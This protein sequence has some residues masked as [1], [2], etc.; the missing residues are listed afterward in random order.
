ME[1]IAAAQ[2]DSDFIHAGTGAFR[3]LNV[4]MFAAA[5]S[6]FA[7]IYCVQPLMPL[8]ATSFSVTP[9]VSSL[10]LSMN[11]AALGIAIV[12]AGIVSEV[13]G[14]RPV[15]TVSLIAS[16]LLTLGTAVAPDWHTLLLTRA[17]AGLALSGV[18]AVAVAY[19]TEEVDPRAGGLAMGLYVAGTAFGGMT[20]RLL[21]G[22]LADFLSWRWAIAGIG[23]L[24]L[25]ASILFR[26]LLPPSRHFT[27]REPRL[28]L[29]GE[30]LRSHLTERG[31]LSLFL[32]GFLLMGSFVS[33][34]NYIGFR[35]LAPPYR[36]SHAAVGLIFVIYLIGMIASAWSGPLAAR[37]GSH[38]VLWTMVVVMLAGLV[39]T[40]ASPL[41]IVI[42]GVA[43]MTFGFFGGH[44][45]LSAWIGRR[46][47]RAKALASSLYL[48]FFYAGSSIAGTLTGRFWS[49]AGWNGVSAAVGVLL[50]MALFVALG[51]RRV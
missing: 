4:A 7:L 17:L 33:V 29:L 43:V 41:P 42:L 28:S 44:T 2:A 39:I 46:A 24:S 51:L 26:A 9:A 31:M 23:A 19:V 6:T 25:G 50:L 32:A 40:I 27:P 18:P 22:V 14:R 12:F 3:R 30:S 15:M 34:Y 5:F 49:A 16:A 8:L 35:L 37:L 13:W 45:I 11:T 21:A 10:A 48:L 20:G 1:R 36:L 38:N 47:T